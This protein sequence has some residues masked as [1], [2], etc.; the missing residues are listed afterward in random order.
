MVPK[1]LI[2]YPTADIGRN[3][4]F[5]DYINLLDKPESSLLVSTHGQ[6][7][8]RN[9][10]Q[11]IDAAL[12]FECTHVMFFDDDIAMAP[13][14]VN[15]LLAHD[16]DM[17]TGLYLMRAFPHQPIIFDGNVGTLPKWRYLQPGDSGLIPITNAGLGCALIKTDVFRAMEKPYVRIGQIELDHWSD[18]ID[19]FN[20]ARAA[21]FKLYCDLNVRCGHM[22]KA[23]FWPTMDKDGNWMT[24]YD[25]R[26]MSTVSIP[27]WL[28]GDNMEG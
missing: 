11:I 24:T 7:P 16:V 14:T 17:V 23:V 6:S 5:Y 28:V 10:N 20:R 25:T 9:R 21:G 4:E 27:Q 18:D 8:A 1:V 15:R 13:D 19:F 22:G 26:G 2:G 12:Q 3:P